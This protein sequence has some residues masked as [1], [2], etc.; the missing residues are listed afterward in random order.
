[1]TIIGTG[2][3]AVTGVSFGSVAATAWTV[4]SDTQITVTT[5]AVGSIGTVDVAVTTPTGT[6]AT[7]PADQLIYGPL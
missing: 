7:S 2:F 6:S 5:P 3:T 4:Q 1:M